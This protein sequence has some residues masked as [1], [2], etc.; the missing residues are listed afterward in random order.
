MEAVAKQLG[1]GRRTLSYHVR[2]RKEL[3]SLMAMDVYWS[4]V[5]RVQLP[6]NASW[7]E[8]LRIHAKSLYHCL[9]QMGPLGA[10]VQFPGSEVTPG[11]LGIA[12]ATL[13]ALT[14][15]GFDE[16]EALRSFATV[17][18][19]AASMAAERQLTEKKGGRHR[20]LTQVLEL[21]SDLPN[22]E[23]PTM[24]AAIRKSSPQR[25]EAVV[26]FGVELILEGIEARLTKRNVMLAG[27]AKSRKRSR[28]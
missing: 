7:Q 28:S 6:E 20:Q 3:V 16:A 19:Y 25:D 23:F 1:V 4:L 12:E 14:E 18:R 9:V 11:G 13:R 8:M 27:R 26:D 10:Y 24:R 15:A 2:D 21:L 17:I 22:D 5:E